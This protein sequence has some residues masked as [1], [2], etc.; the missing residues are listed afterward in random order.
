MTELNILDRLPIGVMSVRNGA[1]A[2]MNYTLRS[3]FAGAF[4]SLVELAEAFPGTAGLADALERGE[5]VWISIGDA[6]FYVDVTGRGQDA[7]IVVFVPLHYIDPKDPQLRELRELYT[8]FQEIFHNCFDGIYVADGSGRS[9]WLNEGFERA[10]GL[11]ARDFV[12]RDARELE[13]LGYIKPLI[14]WKVI[15]TKQRQSVVQRTKAGKSV[16]ATGIPLFDERGN[17]R[18]VIINSRDLTELVALQQQLSEAEADLARARSELAQ[19]RLETGRVD[20]VTWSSAAMQAVVDLGLRLARVDTTLLIQ[21]ESGVGKDVIARLIHTEGTR[22]DGPFVK[23]N[24]GAI[25][26][27]LLESELFGYESGAFTGARKEGK[28]GLFEAAHGGTLFLDEIGEMPA[29]LQVKLLQ[30]LEDRTITRLGSTRTVKVDLRLIAATNRDL[31]SM[32]RE[33]TFREDLFYRL[34]VAPIDIPPLRE[35][36]EDIAPL[37]QRFLQEINERYGFARR[38]S[39][40][41]MD[42]LLRHT[43]P[44]NVRELRNVVE[45]LAVIAREDE[46]GL[47]TLPSDLLAENARH[48]PSNKPL[49]AAARNHEVETVQATVERLGSIGRAAAHLGVSESTVKR[50]LREGRRPLSH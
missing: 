26:T 34:S 35:R 19:L 45:R 21:G 13:R 5:P 20:R 39:G 40:A 22:Q 47:E 37:I 48:A 16:L 43:W 4:A 46:I 50:R 2:F 25:P 32:V 17:V 44:G 1:I 28:A 12:G 36:P 49:K 18:K 31:K 15:T 24:C 41:V 8:D 6:V 7:D 42:R 11:Q 3:L 38:I 23:I 9:L 29:P 33:R 30:V 10:Y 14:T 27:E